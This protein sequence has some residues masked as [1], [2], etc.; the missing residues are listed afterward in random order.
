[1]RRGAFS[2]SRTDLVV[3]KTCPGRTTSNQVIIATH[4]GVNRTWSASRE[5]VGCAGDGWN[6]ERESQNVVRRGVKGP[7]DQ[8]PGSTPHRAPHSTR[9]STQG[10]SIN[11]R[12]SIKKVGLRAGSRAPPHHHASHL[13]NSP[14]TKALCALYGTYV[15]YVLESGTPL[16]VARADSPPG[17]SRHIRAASTRYSYLSNDS[18]YCAILSPG[19]VAFLQGSQSYA[20]CSQSCQVPRPNARTT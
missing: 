6:T 12:N 2:A 14:C 10:T 1:M 3:V 9:D 8:A 7:E 17:V 5:S 18:H 20:S 16:V 19:A 11:R 15:T 13:H 4:G